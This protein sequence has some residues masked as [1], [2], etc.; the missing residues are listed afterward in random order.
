MLIKTTFAAGNF[1][2]DTNKYDTVL[3]CGFI[4]NNSRNYHINFTE[5]LNSYVYS[6]SS[7]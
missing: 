7:D 4:M 5:K 1:R 3:N 6:R 2:I